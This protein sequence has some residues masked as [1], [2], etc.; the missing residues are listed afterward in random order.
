VPVFALTAA[1]VET[2]SLPTLFRGRDDPLVQLLAHPPGL[3]PAGF[4]LPPG[5]TQIVEGQLRRKVFPGR[6]L[7]E[8]WRDGTI[9]F[10]TEATD[11]L[12]WGMPQ[13]APG[14]VRINPMAL[15]ESTY[16]FATLAHRV[17]TEHAAPQP[18]TV[19]FGLTFFAMEGGGKRAVLTPDRLKSIRTQLAIEAK[20]A[21][22]AT[23]EIHEQVAAPWNPGPVAYQLLYALYTWF[24]FDDS[25]IPYVAEEDGVRVVSST[26]ILKDG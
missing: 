3:R 23:H 12:C 5:D 10:V 7:L 13:P 25:A 8:C 15:V 4:D 9:I 6:M 16:A 14:V 21:P 17:Y 20:E 11:Y 18:R 26:E 19:E 2:I 22:A 1:P 24:G